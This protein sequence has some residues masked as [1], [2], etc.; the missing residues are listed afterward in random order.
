MPLTDTDRHRDTGELYAREETIWS[1]YTYSWYYF[2]V[3][4]LYGCVL[5]MIA[6]HD[7]VYCVVD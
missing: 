3:D 6:P 1:Y 4:G 2:L 5:L 7:R